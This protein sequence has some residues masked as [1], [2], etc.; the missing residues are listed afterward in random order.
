MPY[1][2]ASD[3][4]STLVGGEKTKIYEFYEN[5]FETIGSNVILP[6]KATNKANIY[7]INDAGKEITGQESR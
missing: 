5:L 7:W 6:C 1:S 4:L 2:I 3:M